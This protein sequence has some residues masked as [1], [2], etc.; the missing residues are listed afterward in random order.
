[1]TIG[2]MQMNRQM[3]QM[4]GEGIMQMAP[5]ESLQSVEKELAGDPKKA[6]MLLVKMLMDQGIPEEEAIKIAMQMIQSV[7][8][9]GMG[10]MNDERVEARF[11]GR[12]GYAGGGISNIDKARDMLQKRAPGGEFLAYINP[13]EAGILRALGGMGQDINGTGVPSFFNPFKAVKNVVK[14]AARAVKSIAKS[15]IGQIALAVAAPYAIGYLAPG[16]ATLGGSGIMGAALRG[17]ISNMAISALTGQKIDPRNVLLS[18]GISGGLQGLG[19]GPKTNL[20]Q[21][22]TT[23]T[24]TAIPSV[25]SLPQPGSFVDAGIDSGFVVPDYT[26]PVVSSALPSSAGTM[27][28]LKSVVSPDSTLIQRGQAVKD[29]GSKALD[30]VF[31]KTAQDGTRELDKMAV[32]AALSTIPSYLDA[33]KTADEAGIEGFDEAAYNA[34]RDKYMKRYK[35]NL[36]ASSFGIQ[37]AANGGRI[38]YREG[39]SSQMAM[40]ADMIKRGMDEDTISSITNLTMDQIKQIKQGMTQKKANGGRIGYREGTP[41]E[42][43]ISLTDEDSGVIYRDPKTG[44]PLTTTEFLRKSLQEDED[45]DRL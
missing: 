5:Q 41:R 42:G 15:P 29:L 34:E 9:G 39:M 24:G 1:M 27:D 2:R 22:G 40:A 6:F 21:T 25:S 7:A 30:T 32:L 38:G 23:A 45:R 13:E 20:G 14:G 4:G 28:L 11:G 18:A 19:F 12:M 43:I 17:G 37:A 44:E 10:E 31:Y 26:G 8:Q 33:K 35:A 16:F 3:Y 36:P